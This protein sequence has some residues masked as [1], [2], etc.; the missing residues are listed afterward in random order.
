MRTLLLTG[1]ATLFLATGTAHAEVTDEQLT[2]L[3]AYCL[4]MAKIS[5]NDDLEKLLP[6]SR[7]EFSKACVAAAI[8]TARFRAGQ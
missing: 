2:R 6:G 5:I 1:I 7:S 4:D 8:R 3:A